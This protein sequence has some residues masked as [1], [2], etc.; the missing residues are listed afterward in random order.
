MVRATPNTLVDMTK[1]LEKEGYTHDFTVIEDRITDRETGEVLNPSEFKIIE[2]HRFEG[3][4]D[5]DDSEV[6]YALESRSGVKGLLVDAYGTYADPVKS[7]FIGGIY[8][9]KPDPKV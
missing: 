3:A 8:K 2:S 7:K 4:S 5:P 9:P 6:I 1:K